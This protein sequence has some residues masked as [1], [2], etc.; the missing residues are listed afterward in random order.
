MHYQ[1][2]RTKFPWP[3]QPQQQY[4]GAT[5]RG[6]S[7]FAS[8]A[9]C[10]PRLFSR[11]LSSMCEPRRHDENTERIAM[12]RRLPIDDQWVNPHNL[13]LA[14]FANASV[15]VLPFAVPLAFGSCC[16]I[17][18]VGFMPKIRVSLHF[19]KDPRFGCDH[20]RQYAAK[21]AS[22]GVAACAHV[23]HA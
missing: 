3:H 16:E 20:A 21:Y 4:D 5:P 19:T 18:S 10:V 2:G 6:R 15:H 17:T 12:Q 14:M 7:T 11:M 22:P 23:W 1:D 13:C 8:V 9:S